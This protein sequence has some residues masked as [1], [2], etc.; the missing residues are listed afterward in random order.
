M[1]F[2]IGKVFTHAWQITWK[3]KILWVFN[4]FPI[5]LS[6]LFIPI[7]F[8][9]MF[10][11]G[12]NA[13]INQ[14]LIDEPRYVGVFIG[15]GIFL[16]I[17]SILSY[18][19]GAASSSLGI[20]RVETGRG[21]LAF[22]DLLEDGIKYFW[23]ILGV[24]FLIGTA[25]CAVYLLLFGCMTLFGMATMGL[26]MICFQPLYLLL[27]PAMLIVYALVEESEAAVVADN[28]G[29]IEAISRSWSLIKANFWQFVLISILIYF[30]IFILSSIVTLP[31]VAPFFF[32][33]LIADGSPLHIDFQG[34]GWI[35]LLMSLIFLPLLALVQGISLTF[36]KSVFMIVY[37]QL[38][39]SPTLQPVSQQSTP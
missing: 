14:R 32:L 39:R 12:P 25:V 34:L 24:T 6:F 29:A 19:W 18:A 17:L 23:R 38:T 33:P 20:L 21:Q 27:Y 3:N 28:T 15:T 22:R 11:L 7:V 35:L 31:L 26:G 5:L 37:L 16:S 13:L 9:P 30:S 36:M 8:I 2:D 1:N 10:F 4:M